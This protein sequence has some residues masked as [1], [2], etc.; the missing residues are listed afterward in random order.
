MGRKGEREQPNKSFSQECYAVPQTMREL[1]TKGVDI[2]L[3]TLR[4]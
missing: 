3:E 1:N 2:T 4:R